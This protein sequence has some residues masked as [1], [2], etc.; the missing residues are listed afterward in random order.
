MSLKSIL[1]KQDN[2]ICTDLIR[3]TAIINSGKGIPLAIAI[4]TENIFLSKLDYI[5]NNPVKEKW[6]L[7]RY[8]EEYKWSS[9]RFYLEGKDE[10]GIITHYKD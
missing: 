5:H 2:Y 8:P 3:V 7:C 9:A 10:F 4:T 1:Y 6:N